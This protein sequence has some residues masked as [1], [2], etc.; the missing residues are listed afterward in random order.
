MFECFGAKLL[1]LVERGSAD[2]FVDNFMV[3]YLPF[4]L[5]IHLP[6]PHPTGIKLQLNPKLLHFLLDPSSASQNFE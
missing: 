2:D 3:A 6:T 4:Y 5:P 1:C